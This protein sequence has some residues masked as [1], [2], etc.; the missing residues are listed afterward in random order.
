[1]TF[2]DFCIC[3]RMASLRM[4]LFNRDLFFRG[5]TSNVNIS[6]IVKASAK[7]QGDIY[8]F[9]HLPS[10]SIIANVVLFDLDLVFQG[11]IFQMSISRKR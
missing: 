4:L 1:M 6:K 7:L 8:K 5:Q 3:Y 10:N 11:Q 9:Q 2:V